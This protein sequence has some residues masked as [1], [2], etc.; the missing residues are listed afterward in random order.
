ML[1]LCLKQ[2]QNPTKQKHHTQT[3]Y[4][5]GLVGRC[6]FSCSAFLVYFNFLSEEEGNQELVGIVLKTVV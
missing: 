3:N 4:R 5:L 6:I 1:S 2:Q